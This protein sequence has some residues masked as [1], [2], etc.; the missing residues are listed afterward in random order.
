M[1]CRVAV[2]CV[3]VAYFV[4]VF[5]FDGV[6]SWE[7]WCFLVDLEVV[8]FAFFLWFLSFFFWD[9]G[10]EVSGSCGV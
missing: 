1:T 3:V 7:V 4:A 10:V 5:V 9:D 8:R 6:L 2:V